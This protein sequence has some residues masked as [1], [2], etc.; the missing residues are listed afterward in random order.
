MNIGSNIFGYFLEWLFDPT[1]KL[2]DVWAKSMSKDY[3]Q[4]PAYKEN[5][6]RLIERNRETEEEKK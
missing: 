4:D 2:G 6:K 1:R 3:R 5:L